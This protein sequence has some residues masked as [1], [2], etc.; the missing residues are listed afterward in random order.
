MPPWLWQRRPRPIPAARQGAPFRVFAPHLRLRRQRPAISRLTTRVQLRPAQ[1]ANIGHMALPS[2]A[3]L[4]RFPIASYTENQRTECS[5]SRTNRHFR[6]SRKSLA[7]A[8]CRRQGSVE[9]GYRHGRQ[10]HC[11]A[12]H[13]NPFRS[14]SYGAPR[15]AQLC[16]TLPLL[17]TPCRADTHRS[18]GLGRLSRA[19]TGVSRRLMPTTCP[20]PSNEQLCK[21]SR[22]SESS[23]AR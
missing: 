9:R 21:L 3:R 15:E 5:L 7:L 22:L 2:R 4:R 19:E 23:S 10:D 13:T 11:F 18:A 6:W 16:R 17:G 8:D 20:A 12:Q 1:A 14:R